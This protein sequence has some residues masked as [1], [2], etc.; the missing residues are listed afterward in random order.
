MFGQNKTEEF[1]ASNLATSNRSAAAELIN[2]QAVA[3]D[4]GGILMPNTTVAINFVIK[5]GAGGA[6]VFNET[7]NL[8]TDANGVFSAQIGAVIS[9]AGVN[10]ANIT[11]WLQVKLNGTSVG[12]TQMA[13][14]PYALHAKTAESLTGGTTLAIGQNYQGG[15]IFWLDA[16][17]QHGLIAATTNQSL[18]LR[19]WNGV[20]RSTG[21]L[22]DGLYAGAMN[23]AMVIA[24]QMADNQSGNF[25][26]KA[27]ADYSVTA[28]GV[29]YGDWYLPSKYEL[30]L[31]YAQKAVIGDFPANT[32]YWS[33][34]ED[35]PL[36][37]WN[38]DFN[39]GAQYSND[40]DTTPIGGVR[41]IR[42]F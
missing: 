20:D 10:W 25:A 12:E 5:N 42:A 17:G 22:G 26:A 21:A 13:S 19:W 33:S 9:L 16:S 35:D 11:P 23:T 34:T 37:A 3:R 30:N 14:V 40:K 31:I 29:T 7:Q 18:N 27:C 1:S 28:S 38:Q 15:I 24:T 2:Y 41:A 4:A 8:T 39:D 32:Y 6:T 36:R